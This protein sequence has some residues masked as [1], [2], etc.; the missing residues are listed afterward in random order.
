MKPDNLS[1]ESLLRTLALDGQTELTP[2]LL[3]MMYE[4]GDNIKLFA[5]AHPSF[6]FKTRLLYE[7]STYPAGVKITEMACIADR[8]DD[9]KQFLKDNNLTEDDINEVPIKW[10]LALLED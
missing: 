8:S 3:L 10:L 4:W 9:Y 7:L 2:S 6:P 5:L 1:V